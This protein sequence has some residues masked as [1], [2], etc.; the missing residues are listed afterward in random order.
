[1]KSNLL[2]AKLRGEVAQADHA[3]ANNEFDREIEVLTERLE[4]SRRTP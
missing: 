4:A 3:Q 2:R 1:M